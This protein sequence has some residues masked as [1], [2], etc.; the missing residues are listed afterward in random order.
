[1]SSA[2]SGCSRFEGV[3]K[4]AVTKT[5]LFQIRN[6]MLFVGAEEVI[7]SN[8]RFLPSPEKRTRGLSF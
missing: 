7:L 6:P 3:V 2:P 8:E 5:A 1:M 4:T